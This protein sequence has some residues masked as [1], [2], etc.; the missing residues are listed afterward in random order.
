[1]PHPVRIDK[2]IDVGRRVR[3]VARVQAEQVKSCHSKLLQ[4]GL[5]LLSLAMASSRRMSGI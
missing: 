5:G 3:F 2:H 1:M 4:G